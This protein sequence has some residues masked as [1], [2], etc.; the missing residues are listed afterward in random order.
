MKTLKNSFSLLV[1]FTLMLT[2]GCTCTVHS[3]QPSIGGNREYVAKERNV[4]NFSSLVVKGSFN[5]TIEQ[6]PKPMVIVDADSNLHQY[7]YTE[8]VDGQLIISQP[9]NRDLRSIRTIRVKVF[10]QELKEIEMV[11]STELMGNGTLNFDTIKF[12]GAGAIKAELNLKGNFIEGEFPGAA[13]IKLAGIVDEAT[14]EFPGAVKLTASELQTRNFSISMAG[15]GK[16]RV[17]V[18]EELNVQIAG[19]GLVSYRGN[20]TKVVSSIGGIGKLTNEETD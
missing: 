20:P 12:S 7:I 15:A 16:A 11:G 8:V 2:T 3:D 14:F 19:A 6:G 1:I 9:Q 17:N 4:D 5:V 18:K 10:Y 13:S